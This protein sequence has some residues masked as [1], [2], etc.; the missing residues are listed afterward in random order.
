MTL[1]LFDLM[2]MTWEIEFE[3]RCLERKINSTNNLLFFSKECF[4]INN[5]AKLLSE[6]EEKINEI[7][8]MAEKALDMIHNIPKSKGTSI[9]PKEEK[10]KH[11]IYGKILKLGIDVMFV[12]FLKL[13]D[14]FVMELGLENRCPVYQ[15]LHTFVQRLECD[16]IDTKKLKEI[17]ETY[18]E[19]T[20]N[21]TD[22]FEEHIGSNKKKANNFKTFILSVIYS[23]NR[24]EEI[25]E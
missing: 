3:C 24:V 9:I 20:L 4:N 12:Y 5:L 14:I 1:Q 22:L 25:E 7:A 18:I 15:K 8:S 16:K 2:R 6:M 13:A 11:P 10:N 17:L 23:T 19:T 21:F